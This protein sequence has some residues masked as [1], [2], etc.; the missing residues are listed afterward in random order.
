M[1]LSPREL[2]KDVVVPTLVFVAFPPDGFLLLLFSFRSNSY[3]TP[4][5]FY[6]TYLLTF[7][8]PFYPAC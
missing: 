8:F 1:K 6:G 2:H 3:V 4:T 5:A 7:I